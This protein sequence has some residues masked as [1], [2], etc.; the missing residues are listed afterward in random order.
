MVRH[1]RPLGPTGVC[2]GRTEIEVAADLATDAEALVTEVKAVDRIVTSPLGRCRRLAE[3]LG[4]RLDV[5][6]AVD[7]R[8]REMDFGHWEGSSWD[9]ISRAEIDAWASDFMFGRPHGGESVAMLLARTKAAI[10]ACRGARGD[11]LVVT[12]AGV[13]R[14]AL[15]AQHG[16]EAAWRSEIRF[17]S[18]ILLAAL[19]GK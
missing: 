18:P 12:H 4:T 13:I 3:V 14:A 15:F 5:G 1:T 6:V 19:P 11:T 2:Y 17:C 10:A 7:N 16:N 8:W 9:D